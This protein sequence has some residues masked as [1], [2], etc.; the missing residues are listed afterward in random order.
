MNLDD[1]RRLMANKK[2]RDARAESRYED[3]M[4]EQMD[5]ED[6]LIA[7]YISSSD[8]MEYVSAAVDQAIVQ[9][10]DESKPLFICF[11][12]MLNENIGRAYVMNKGSW[13]SIEAVIAAFGTDFTRMDVRRLPY[14][15][16]DIVRDYYEQQGFATGELIPLDYTFESDP[17]NRPGKYSQT[18]NC[19]A[20]IWGFQL[21]L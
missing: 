10:V 14:R 6:N 4:L 18:T 12:D 7:E 11:M 15:L 19:K 20:E 2:A 3:S 5:Y 21:V 8:F 16:A 1:V 17:V 9:A 13:N